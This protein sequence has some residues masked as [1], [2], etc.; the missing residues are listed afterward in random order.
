M[1]VPDHHWASPARQQPLQMPHTRGVRCQSQ[2]PSLLSVGMQHPMCQKLLCW[3]YQNPSQIFMTSRQETATQQNDKIKQKHCLNCNQRAG[4]FSIDENATI[5]VE[6][7]ISSTN[8]QNFTSV[9]HFTECFCLLGQIRRFQK[10]VF[11]YLSFKSSRNLMAE[12]HQ[13]AVPCSDGCYLI[14]DIAVCAVRGQFAMCCIDL[15]CNTG[16][17]VLFEV[18][19]LR[20]GLPPQRPQIWKLAAKA[21]RLTRIGSF[22]SR[23]KYTKGG[24]LPSICQANLKQIFFYYY[25]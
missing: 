16:V 5:P 21:L 22:Q 13:L 2:R 18:C 23:T 6:A 15:N 8:H 7:L 4:K 12:F 20:V 1:E 17:L 3:I 19:F 11:S 24:A 14:S 10:T 9:A 25:Y